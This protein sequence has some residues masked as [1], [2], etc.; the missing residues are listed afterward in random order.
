LMQPLCVVV[1]MHTLFDLEKGLPESIIVTE[2]IIHDKAKMNFFVAIPGITYI[3]D[4]GYMDY[5]EYD[6]Y[7]KEGIYFVTR[8]KKNAVMETLSVN[9]VPSE[10]SVLSDKEIILGTFY[11]KTQHSL[12][13]I[14]VMDTTTGEPFCIATTALTLQQRKLP[15]FID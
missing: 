4:R 8:L 14:E 5:K 3:F 6:R 1:K 13:I 12:R 9:A 15:S 2:G 7:S 10:S 11:T